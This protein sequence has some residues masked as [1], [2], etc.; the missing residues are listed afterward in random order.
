MAY[1]SAAPSVIKKLDR[2]RW[3]ALDIFAPL[4][5]LL[6]EMGEMPLKMRKYK[7]GL[8]YL[9]KIKGQNVIVLVKTEL[10]LGSAKKV[11]TN[12]SEELKSMA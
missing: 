2:I 9:I 12:F 10:A 6:I 5:F 3:K 11:K 7:L 1:A 4:H 8:K